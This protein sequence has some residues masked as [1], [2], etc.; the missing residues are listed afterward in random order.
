M[1]LDD[2]DPWELYVPTVGQDPDGAGGEAAGDPGSALPLTAW[3]AR[4]T[5]LPQPVAGVAP[6][7]QG[8]REPV[9][10][11]VVGLLGVLGPPGRHVMLGAV[12]F[13]PQLGQRPRHL[14]A[15]VGLALVQADGDQLQAPVVGEQRRTGMRGEAAL[16]AG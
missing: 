15:R 2:P 9:Q 12:P 13:P 3:E 4:R 16:L 14:D 7:L 10:A 8:P 6:V 1:G 11:T 5:A